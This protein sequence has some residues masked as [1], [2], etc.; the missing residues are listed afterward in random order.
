MEISTRHDGRGVHLLAYLP[1][2]A[3]PPLAAELRRI[4]DGRS[5]R[6]PAMLA[7]LRRLGI[8]ITRTTS[9]G[10]PTAPPRPGGRTSPTRWSR[11]ASCGTATRRSSASST[12]AARRTCDRYAAAAGDDDRRRRRGR[13]R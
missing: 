6:L 13:R 12:P 2:P 11:W 1:D 5:S 9:A 8:D 10:S 4:L 3:Y 7:R